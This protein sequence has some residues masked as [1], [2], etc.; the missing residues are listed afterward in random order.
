MLG[1]SI[2][3]PDLIKSPFFA[4]S[5]EEGRG[6]GEQR[7]IL[8]WDDFRENSNVSSGFGFGLGGASVLNGSLGGAS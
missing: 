2:S 3:Y 5:L 1:F 8:R 4:T 7:P 6:G